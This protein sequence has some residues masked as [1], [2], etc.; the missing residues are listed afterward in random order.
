MKKTF[1]AILLPFLFCT[2][3]HAQSNLSTSRVTIDNVIYYV[4]TVEAGETLY[5]LSQAYNVPVGG[6]IAANPASAEGIRAGQVLKIPAADTP[7]ETPKVNK[8]K[9]IIHTVNQGETLYSISKRYQV[10]LDDI[11]QAN[12]GLVENDIAIGQQIV[13][14]K[15][16]AG[17]ADNQEIDDQWEDYTDKLD[18]LSPQYIHHL[19]QRQETLYSLSRQYNVTEEAL[20]T[21]NPEELKD[22]LKYGSIIKVPNGVEIQVKHAGVGEG[23]PVDIAVDPRG[24][25]PGGDI[26]GRTTPAGVPEVPNAAT[27]RN[28]RVAM[29]LPFT[30][31]GKPNES[32]AKFY[33]GT[34]VA[35]DSLKR[36]GI[37]VTVDVFDTRGEAET[38]VGLLNEPALKNAAVI[39]GPVYEE[40]FA[41]VARFGMEHGI[42]VVS[43]LRVVPESNPYIIQA[44]PMASDKYCDIKGML[45]A[46]SLNVIYVKPASGTDAELTAEYEAVLPPGY[47]TVSYSKAGGVSQF[48]SP[49]R[50][51][52]VNLFVVASNN[53]ATVDDI[54]RFISSVQNGAGDAYKVAVLG[55]HRWGAFTDKDISPYFRHNVFFPASY[56]AD[57]YNPAVA[58]FDR[59]YIAAFSSFPDWY[60]YR[61]YDVMMT[62]TEAVAAYGSNYISMLG[63]TDSAPLQ[64]RYRFVKEEGGKT[65]NE[66]WMIVRYRSDNTI[67]VE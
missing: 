66:R 4:H 19:V 49:M 36:K 45:A 7:V 63:N 61:G 16:A 67:T 46:D 53:S 40:E 58:A 6:I 31:D 42:G 55:N 23:H 38:A 57:K 1:F 21:L 52:K 65:G 22:G 60:S 59:K 32:I 13:I 33:L 2:L 18:A 24:L 26:T 54:L 39:I 30:S 35:L 62:M 11:K 5:S 34:L 14:P 15:D 10:S 25:F 43:P 44:S 56:F 3:S 51:D 9:N 48:K 64:V 17:N 27:G 12:P 41:Q 8:R 50:R 47:S 20:R 37:S 29:M 28:V